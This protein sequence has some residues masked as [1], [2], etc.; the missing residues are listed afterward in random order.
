VAVLSAP[1]AG[2]TS[3]IQNALDLRKP[4]SAPLSSSKV[5]LEDVVY[6]VQLVELSL[7]DVD[8]SNGRRVSWPK[9]VDSNLL[10]HID[11]VLCLYDITNQESIAEI[12]ALLGEFSQDCSFATS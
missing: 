11:G 5:S 6:K 2:K 8:F 3:F 1:S 4:P 12:P 9:H 10:P 7:D